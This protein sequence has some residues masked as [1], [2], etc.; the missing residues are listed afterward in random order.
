[1]PSNFGDGPNVSRYSSDS[2]NDSDEKMSIVANSNAVKTE[3]SFEK[4][5]SDD[6]ENDSESNESEHEMNEKEKGSDF[7]MGTASDISPQTSIEKP[8]KVEKEKKPL[9]SP[10]ERKKRLREAAKTRA[11][12]NR[13][14]RLEKNDKIQKRQEEVMQICMENGINLDQKELD[15]NGKM[16]K[17]KHELTDDQLD[18]MNRRFAV[19]FND[20]L[21]FD[22]PDLSEDLSTLSE[23]IKKMR[24]SDDNPSKQK[25]HYHKYVKRFGMV[26]L[27]VSRAFGQIR[28]ESSFGIM[29]R[30]LIGKWPQR[31]SFKGCKNE[32]DGNDEDE[33]PT[34]ALCDKCQGTGH[35]IHQKKK[36][37]H[38]KN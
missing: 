15:E 31:F 3:N 24:Q 13:K 28:D 37:K 30:A 26:A 18:N 6:E 7:E 21:E 29:H 5:I 25:K 1:M 14:A 23:I 35:C 34:D 36:K 16:R 12:K 11:E 9:L 17:T 27:K 33:E 8:K 19:I 22:I 10:E 20:F 2:D 4:R 38:R 32:E